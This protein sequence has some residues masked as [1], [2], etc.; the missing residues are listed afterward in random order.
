MTGLVCGMRSNV[1]LSYDEAETPTV[2]I[3]A[4]CVPMPCRRSGNLDAAGIPAAEGEGAVVGA[5]DAE[6]LRLGAMVFHHCGEEMLGEMRGLEGPRDSGVTQT[7]V[8]GGGK[9]PGILGIFSMLVDI[10]GI[11]GIF[12]VPV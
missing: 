6:V 12:N 3:H 5:A 2:I 10:L 1:K 8:G 4:R 11:P 7:N 9:I